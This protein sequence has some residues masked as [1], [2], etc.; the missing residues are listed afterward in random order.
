MV[1]ICISLKAAIGSIAL[2]MA[3]MINDETAID[4]GRQVCSGIEGAEDKGRH[5]RVISSGEL[6]E[7][8]ILLVV[9]RG[10]VN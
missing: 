6:K 5:E 1:Y 4:Y 2:D 10:Y 9:S 7:G 8:K 3:L